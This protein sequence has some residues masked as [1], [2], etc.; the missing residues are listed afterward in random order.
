L[1]E[2]ALDE[3]GYTDMWQTDK[4]PDAPG[5]LENLKELIHALEDFE[6]L[7]GFLEHISL[8]MEANEASQGDMVN[9]MTLHSAKGLEFD[10]V[11][12]PGWEEG[13]F[14]HQRALDESGQSGL[15]EERRLA[16]VGLTR[17]RRN[18]HL[19][20]A[21][22]RRIHN[23]WQ[24]AVPSRFVDELPTEH[25]EV[26]TEQGL[27][28]SSGV[29]GSYGRDQDSYG[30]SVPGGSGRASSTL[31]RSRNDRASGMSSGTADRYAWRRTGRRS[32][33]PV[34]IDGDAALIETDPQNAAFEI[35]EKVFHDKFGY[36]LVKAVDGDKLVVNFDHS[37]EKNVLSS[38]L[39]K[40]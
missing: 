34:T 20:F 28:A 32:T 37:G 21:A 19:S 15:E 6:N 3:S 26:K 4:S 23:K 24:S 29:T 11:F 12:L 25:V 2:M 13:V 1:A 10:T 22:N 17:A 18:V 33:A 39:Q 35:D 7:G 5:R 36:G 16:Y 30:R 40:T 9:I 14:P 8:V 31:Y 38:F 27:Y